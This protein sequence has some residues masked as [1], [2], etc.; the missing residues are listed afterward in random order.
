MCEHEWDE[1][2]RVDVHVE[3]PTVTQGK[4]R[5]AAWYVRCV[6]CGQDGYRRH[7]HSKLIYTWR[8]NWN[9]DVV[10]ENDEGDG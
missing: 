10:P 5:V 9:G 1:T 6:K 8:K 3:W 4:V 2:G 7:P